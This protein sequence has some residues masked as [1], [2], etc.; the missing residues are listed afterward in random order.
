MIIATA[1]LRST[2]PQN[3][4]EILLA[5]SIQKN[6]TWLLAHKDHELTKNQV[7]TYEALCTRRLKNE[8]IAYIVGHK[9]FY[10]RNFLVDANVL[11]PRPA[12]ETLIAAVT[13]FLQKKERQIYD[14]DTQVIVVTK[15][16]STVQPEIVVD[17]G[18]GS[19]CIAIT[20]ALEHAHLPVIATDISKDALDVAR[21]NIQEYE[22]EQRIELR[23]GDALEPL[24]NVEL[25][26]LLVSNPPYIPSGDVLMPDVQ[27]F[28]PHTALF[29]GKNGDDMVRQ[30]FAAAHAHP[31]CIGVCMECRSEHGIL[32]A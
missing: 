6:R 20:L 24:V 8:P 31:K 3:E 15:R 4:A 1:L 18:T 23:Q 22:L 2:I 19:G 7:D 26:F 5:H 21:K 25:P 30:I 10:G 14:A 11:I 27:Q 13:D 28:E 12:T 29:S 16:Y 9:E 17:I 32:A